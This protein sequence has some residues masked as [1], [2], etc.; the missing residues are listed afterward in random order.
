MRSSRSER[1]VPK[2]RALTCLIVH[3]LLIETLRTTVS[4]SRLSDDT[5]PIGHAL[6]RDSDSSSS[7]RLLDRTCPITI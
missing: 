1:P 5:D 3:C 7:F 2:A 4:Q 6:P